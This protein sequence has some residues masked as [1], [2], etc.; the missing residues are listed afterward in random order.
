[1]VKI[2][3]V[4]TLVD[5]KKKEAFCGNLKWKSLSSSPDNVSCRSCV[6]K[7]IRTLGYPGNNASMTWNGP[8]N[9]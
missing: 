2:H 1:M 7:M 9:G 3:W 5:K 6:L 8:Y 4:K